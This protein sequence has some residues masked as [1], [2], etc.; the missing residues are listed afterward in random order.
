MVKV[1][2]MKNQDG[3]DGMNLILTG[4]ILFHLNVMFDKHWF[5]GTYLHYSWK[6]PS[7]STANGPFCNL[8]R[9]VPGKFLFALLLLQVSFKKQHQK[10][11]KQGKANKKKDV[12]WCSSQER[13]AGCS[14]TDVTGNN[15]DHS[16]HG[17]GF[18]PVKSD[19]ELKKDEQPTPAAVWLTVG[20]IETVVS[21]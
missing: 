3:T 6:I 7:N 14:E 17:Q 15:W 13:L 2:R 20:K 16:P 1:C 12:L 11:P 5:R 18:P 21:N 4:L 10:N 19:S 8:W 9:F